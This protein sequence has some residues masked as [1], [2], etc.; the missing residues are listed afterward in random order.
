MEQLTQMAHEG[1]AHAEDMMPSTPW[2]TNEIALDSMAIVVLVALLLLGKYA[3]KWQAGTL[4]IAAMTYLLVIGLTMYRLSPALSIA[5][6]AI[7][8]GAALVSSFMQLGKPHKA[9]D[10]RVKKSHN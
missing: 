5:A 3:F 6:L 9:D 1:H 2:W 4:L 10:Q 8:L 7:G